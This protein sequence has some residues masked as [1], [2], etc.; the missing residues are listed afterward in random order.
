MFC[1]AVNTATSLAAASGLSKRELTHYL[2]VQSLNLDT[3]FAFQQ[4]QLKSRLAPQT[5]RF[6]ETDG[7]QGF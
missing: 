6:L 7:F 1:G 4:E 3:S 2:S 5:A